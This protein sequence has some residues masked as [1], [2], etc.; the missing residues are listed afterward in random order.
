MNRHAFLGMKFNQENNG[1]DFGKPAMPLAGSPLQ[2][3]TKARG[4][5]SSRNTT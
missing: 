1:T 2:A 4:W 3:T 5:R